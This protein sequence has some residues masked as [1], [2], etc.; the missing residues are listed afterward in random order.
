MP[1]PILLGVRLL[2]DATLPSHDPADLLSRPQKH[3]DAMD[4]TSL[5]VSAVRHP[6]VVA[7]GA[8]S[9]DVAW[10]CVSPARARVTTVAIMRPAPRAPLAGV[11]AV[12]IISGLAIEMVGEGVTSAGRGEVTQS[13]DTSRVKER[14]SVERKRLS[15]WK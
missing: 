9:A 2:E 6:Q 7:P 5:P 1:L 15:R 3:S 8:P 4:W 10:A 13:S 14:D 12:F 11:I